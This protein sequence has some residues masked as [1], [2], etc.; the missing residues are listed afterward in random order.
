[1][2]LSVRGCTYSFNFRYHTTSQISPNF[3]IIGANTTK[4]GSGG[5]RT[6]Y[7]MCHRNQLEMAIFCLVF[8]LNEVCAYPYICAHTN[9]RFRTTTYSKK[10]TIVYQVYRVFDITCRY[11]WP[12][13]SRIVVMY[14]LPIP[15]D[16]Q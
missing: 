12:Y 7:S 8:S 15:G 11:L 5:N 13:P 3:E 10:R 16:V 4:V 2:Y 1:M 14:A 6:S 9:T